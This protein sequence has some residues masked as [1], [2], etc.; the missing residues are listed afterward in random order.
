MP[1]GLSTAAKNYQGPIVWL[2]DVTTRSGT[3]HYFA[4]DQFNFAGNAYLPYLRLLSGPRFTRT[5]EADAGE[6]ELLNAD[7]LLSSLAAGDDFE[8]ALCELRQLLVGIESAVL[9]FRGL[10]TEQEET[11]LGLRFRLVSELDP[12][13][14]ALH[15]R[16]YAQLCTWQFSRPNRLTPCGY[17]PTAIGDV[18][19]AFFG[20]RAADIFSS[21]TIGDSTLNETADAHQN[22]IAVITAGT[23][24][25]QKRRIR[26][27]SATTFTLYHPWQTT[28]DATSRFRVFTLPAG[29]PR[30]LLTPTSGKL[31]SLAT[32][33]SARA[34]TDTG[35]AMLAD[36]HKDALL[37][38]VSGAAATQLRRIG[39]NSATVVT[40]ADDEPDF[41]PA[42]QL[43][44]KFRILYPA[45]PK[46]FAPSCEDHARTQ[47]FNGFP[48]LVPLLR[49]HF[50]G[51]FAPGGGSGGLPE[52]GRGRIDPIVF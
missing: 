41:S 38:V 1:R 36:E 2:A 14:I 23:G 45:C 29:A 6:I 25:G 27:N 28:P 20:E 44:D 31:E 7:G 10:L 16:L 37:Y 49:R 5:L 18:A 9:V 12:A 22:R 26:S 21:T 47:A 48:T 39:S 24:R 17:N 33:A 42:P 3:K 46:D 19:E 40:L 30:L 35:L 4:E 11:D 50:G 32:G 15:A 8:G 52:R 13:H 43:G 51:R 34:I